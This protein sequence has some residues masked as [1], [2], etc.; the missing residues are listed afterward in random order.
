MVCSNTHEYLHLRVYYIKGQLNFLFEL[1]L[2][3][4]LL[5]D[6]LNYD[7]LHIYTHY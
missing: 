1:P 4:G 7:C 5:V 2:T 3:E 6:H